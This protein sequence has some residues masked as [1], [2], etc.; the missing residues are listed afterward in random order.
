MLSV[1]DDFGVPPEKIRQWNR[2][3]GNNLRAGRRLV[4]YKPVG[5]A[6]ERR[7]A[8][9]RRGRSRKHK[10]SEGE[11]LFSIAARY[12]TTVKALRDLNNLSSSL[13]HPGDVLLIP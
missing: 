6:P 11:T 12:D 7:V 13:L 1:A 9:G 10:V 3:K 4:I 8:S 5:P 2:L